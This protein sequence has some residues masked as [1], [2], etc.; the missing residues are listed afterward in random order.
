MLNRRTHAVHIS[1]VRVAPHRV[2]LVASSMPLLLFFLVPVVATV[3]GNAAGK[4]IE[5]PLVV[6]P[7]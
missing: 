6:V 2:V 7:L 4:G 3:A 5:V 1:W